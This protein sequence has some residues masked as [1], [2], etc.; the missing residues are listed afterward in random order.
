MNSISMVNSIN[1]YRHKLSEVHERYN[2]LTSL[3]KDLQLNYNLTPIIGAEIE[4]Y[5]S[6]NIYVKDLESKIGHDIKLEKGKN[7]Y[8]LDLPPSSNLVTMARDIESVR[9][10]ICFFA[11][12]LIRA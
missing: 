6:D 7:Q 3:Q 5:L 4:F 10:D 8:E 9:K 11:K 2:R 12:Q 1:Q